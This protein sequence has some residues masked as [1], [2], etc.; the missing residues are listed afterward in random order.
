MLRHNYKRKEWKEYLTGYAFIFPIIAFIVIFIAYPI[1]QSLMLSFYQW[2]AVSE[3]VFV[4]FSNYIRMFT[5]DYLFFTALKNSTIFAIGATI[6]TVVVGFIF[7]VLIDFKIKFWKAYRFVFFLPYVYSVVIVSLLW[8]KIFDQNGVFNSLL[9]ILHLETLQ[10]TWFA[11]P[12]T[13]MGIILF[14]TIWQFAS[15]PMVLFL[16]GMQSINETIYE[17]AKID[18]ASTMRRI[19]SVTIPMLKNVF[20]V[21]IMIQIIYSF[22]VFDIIYVMTKGGPGGS[23]DVLG[24]ILYKYA[25]LHMKFGYSSVISVLMFVIAIVFALIYIRITGYGSID[26]K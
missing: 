23:T 6:G 13:A 25:F 15:V 10:R 19:F 3:K 8:R 1:M 7:A 11:N 5:K 14:V 21:I 4:G 18:G 22:K 12:N 17:A 2:D 9:G 16:A 26:K 20:I 24:T